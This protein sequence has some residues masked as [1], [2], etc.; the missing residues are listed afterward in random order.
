MA[1][2][3][4]KY[5][6]PAKP[7]EGEGSPA[8][9]REDAAGMKRTGMSARE[10]EASAEDRAQD[11]ARS[12]SGVRDAAKPPA[13][14]PRQDAPDSGGAPRDAAEPKPRAARNTK[15]DVPLTAEERFYRSAT[16]APVKGIR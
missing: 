6:H 5:L 15:S 11:R 7:R 13:K 2:N 9:R 10:W 3:L 16:P 1:N 4:G 12:R 14:A 8:D